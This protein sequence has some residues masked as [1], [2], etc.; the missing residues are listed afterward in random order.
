MIRMT[1]F[2]NLLAFLALLY[3][4]T[5][6][7]NQTTEVYDTYIAAPKLVPV[8]EPLLGPE[9]NI[10]AYRNKLFVKAPPHIQDEILDILQELDRPL[11]NVQI[12][13]RFADADDLA[14]SDSEASGKVVVYHGSSRKTGVDVEVVSKQRFSTKQD[15]VDQQVRVLEG[16]QGVLNIGKDVLVQQYVFVNPFQARS[17]QQYR[18]VGNAMYVVPRLVKNRIRIEVFSSNQRLRRNANSE[19]EK[20][21]AQTVLLV[22]PGVWTPLAG[23]TQSSAESD[24]S[25]THSTSRNR[26]QGKTLQIR[27]DI[28]D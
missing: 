22:E 6:W 9:D 15:K 19:I 13:L 21:E 25:I 2:S 14:A 7:A 10:T 8:L 4:A 16:E 20:V 28:V 27:A 26:Q 3:S 24:N 5:A 1:A 17:S 18:S 23:S 12:S 11:K